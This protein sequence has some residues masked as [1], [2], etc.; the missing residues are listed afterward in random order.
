MTSYNGQTGEILWDE[1]HSIWFGGSQKRNKQ[2]AI[3]HEAV[4]DQEWH[5]TSSG[6]ELLTG[7][8]YPGMAMCS[9]TNLNPVNNLFITN[10]AAG[11]N[12]VEDSWRIHDFSPY[13]GPEPVSEGK[14][15]GAYKLEKHLVSYLQGTWTYTLEYVDLG[16]REKPWKRE[17]LRDELNPKDR[18][19]TVMLWFKW[20]GVVAVSSPANEYE[21]LFNRRIYCTPKRRRSTIPIWR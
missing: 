20:G 2:V 7:L 4:F 3:L 5:L 17:D 21:Y 1:G 13:K 16:E 14:F 19:W 11:I 6:R 9:V 8:S 12:A 15:S 18:D 10:G